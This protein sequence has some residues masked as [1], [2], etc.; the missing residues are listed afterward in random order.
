MNSGD[1]WSNI[2]AAKK[3]Q[4]YCEI[5]YTIQ[6]KIGRTIDG[7]TDFIVDLY[8]YAQQAFKMTPEDHERLFQLASEEK[9]II[10]FNFKFFSF[11]NNFLKAPILILNCEVLEAC[12]LE[13]K[14]ANGFSDPYCMLGIVPGNRKTPIDE[15]NDTVTH[16]LCKLPTVQ[17]FNINQP[18][19]SAQPSN[20]KSSLIK[21]FSSFRR[22]EKSHPPQSLNFA[23]DSNLNKNKSTPNSNLK[24][25]GVSEKLPAKYIQATNV[26]KAT[27]NPVWNESFRL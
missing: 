23:K 10:L 26:K 3:D 15:Q 25:T 2:S 14:D 22:S 8:K 13:A 4:L 19:Q 11:I 18:L 1:P 16:S 21:R 24:L 9:V 20:Q 27:L 7:H 17:N 12:D 5:I 6:H